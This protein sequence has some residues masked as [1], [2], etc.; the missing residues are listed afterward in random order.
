MKKKIDGSITITPGKDLT[1]LSHEE[2]INGLD[3]IETSLNN[4]GMAMQ[5]MQE[6]DFIESFQNIL[7]SLVN[8]LSPG[9]FIILKNEIHPTPNNYLAQFIP[10][11]EDMQ[12]INMS[13][14][15]LENAVNKLDKIERNQNNE[16][17]INL[18]A[19]KIF[20]RLT[21]F[22]TVAI[23]Q[24]ALSRDAIQVLPWEKSDLE[25]VRQLSAE[26]KTI[27]KISLE[28]AIGISTVKRMRNFLGITRN[29]KNQA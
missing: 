8:S 15:D 17:I 16:R 14:D 2:F 6:D 24:D 4:M 3:R 9:M 28:M 20:I 10:S 19:E 13:R 18:I 25:T 1:E 22:R 21:P 27:Q 12:I 11:P 7:N 29:K 5:A 23:G 26:G